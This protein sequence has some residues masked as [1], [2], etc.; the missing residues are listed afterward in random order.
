MKCN[1][2]KVQILKDTATVI[3]DLV[4]GNPNPDYYHILELLNNQLGFLFYA[5]EELEQYDPN[6]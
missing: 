3:F 5:I 6:S 4:D 1:D 2:F